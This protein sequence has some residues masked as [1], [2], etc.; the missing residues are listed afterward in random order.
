MMPEADE[1]W[2]DG[3]DAVADELDTCP[4]CG[5]RLLPFAMIAH[6]RFHAPAGL[7]L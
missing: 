7:A 1:S 4:D 3:E 5:M 2:D 6:R